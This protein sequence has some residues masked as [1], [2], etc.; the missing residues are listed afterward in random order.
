MIVVL[1]QAFPPRPGGIQN[2]LAGTAEYIA[3]AGHDVTV[4][5]DGDQSAQHWDCETKTPYDV[6]RFGG[7]KFLRR[8]RKLKR[9]NQIVSERP[10]EAI[11]ADS[12]KSLELLSSYNCPIVVW[13]HGNE[14]SQISKKHKRISNAL[15][16]ADHIMF[17]SLETKSRAAAFLSEKTSHSIVHPPIHKSFPAS[18]Q[19]TQ[20]AAAVWQDSYPK[21]ISLARLVELKG[22]DR[23]IEAMPEI[24]KQYPKAKLIIA[25]IGEDQGRLENLVK[26]LKIEPSVSFIGWIEGGFKTALLDEADL[27]LQPGRQI[28]EEREGYGISYIEAALHGLPSISGNAGGAPEA[29]IDGK[30]GLVV[31]AST[32]AHVG[33]AVLAILNDKSKH[34]AMRKEAREHG[35]THLWENRI[36]DVLRAAG[37]EP[38]DN[39]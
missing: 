37:L 28:A 6:E 13:A 1:A 34:N 7:I 11:F 8:R 10:V 24:L 12:W 15:L 19:D 38:K 22:I 5:A 32:S 21:L 39:Y 23:A 2:L 27:F 14:F 4:L 18:T 36:V 33:Q 35:Q 31:D 16:K 17:I 9:L 3:E 26:D 25:G 20:K 30:T 29:I